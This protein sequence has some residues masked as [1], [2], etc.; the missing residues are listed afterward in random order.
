[1]RLT[2]YLLR[3]C[4]GRTVG[5]D[6]QT[7]NLIVITSAFDHFHILLGEA[8]EG[9]SSLKQNGERDEC[10]EVHYE[11]RGVKKSAAGLP[12]L[13]EHPQPYISSLFSQWSS[14]SLHLRA[15][16]TP[17]RDF[18]GRLSRIKREPIRRGLRAR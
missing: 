16:A 10:R 2:R 9:K 3:R 8:R 4:I 7:S 17:S 15:Q 18:T 1:M 13:Q 5:E 14:S 6:E 11:R 12:I